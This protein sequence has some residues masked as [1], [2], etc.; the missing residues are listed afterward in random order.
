MGFEKYF[1]WMNKTKKENL[2][3]LE[4]KDRTS[5]LTIIKQQ[6]RNPES[7]FIALSKRYNNVLGAFKLNIV[8]NG[9]EEKC[10]F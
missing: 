9:D 5:F 8:N 7:P 10:F 2:K 4:N 3:T 6:A 1:G